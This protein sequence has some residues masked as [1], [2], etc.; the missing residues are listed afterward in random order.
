MNK[1][2]AKQGG[3]K[4]KSFSCEGC[5]S[6]SVCDKTACSD[7]EEVQVDSTNVNTTGEEA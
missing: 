2:M 7:I 6:A 5:P 3:V 1:I 4:R